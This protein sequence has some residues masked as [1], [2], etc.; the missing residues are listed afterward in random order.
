MACLILTASEVMVSI[1]CLEFAYTQSQIN[2]ILGYGP[3]LLT[4]SLGNYLTSAIKFLLTDSLGQSVLSGAQ[5]L[6][7]DSAYGW[8]C[9]TLFLP[10]SQIQ[11]FE[12]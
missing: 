11:T 7:L 12:P 6:V 10:F 9:Y 4:V 2:E 5:A 1:T 8:G 3:F